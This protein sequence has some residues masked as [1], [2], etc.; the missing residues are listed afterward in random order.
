LKTLFPD[1]HQFDIPI[2]L[3]LKSNNTNQLIT[4]GNNELI[5]DNNKYSLLNNI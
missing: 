5:E 4:F 3:L 2:L 1:V